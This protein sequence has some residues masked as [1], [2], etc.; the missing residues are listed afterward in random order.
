[1]GFLDLGM[2]M[3]RFPC[4]FL[5]MRQNNALTKIY[6]LCLAVRKHTYGYFLIFVFVSG[7][8]CQIIAIMHRK[9]LLLEAQATDWLYSCLL[10]VLK[11]RL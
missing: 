10:N 11:S 9:R 4:A 2:E 7:L 6:F 8:M 5:L 3:K 1:M